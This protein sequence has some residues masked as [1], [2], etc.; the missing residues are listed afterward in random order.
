METTLH[1]GLCHFL[2]PSYVSPRERRRE[3][4]GKAHV[5]TCTGSYYTR[6]VIITHHLHHVWEDW[7]IFN[8][9]AEK[10]LSELI[11]LT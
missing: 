11:N 3:K 4:R 5:S 2:W 8:R 10:H 7:S 9:W 6:C 1:L